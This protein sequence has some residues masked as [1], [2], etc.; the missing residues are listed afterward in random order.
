MA[1][2]IDMLKGGGEEYI[3]YPRAHENIDKEINKNDILGVL[4]GIHSVTPKGMAP[5]IWETKDVFN[6][7]K[8]PEGK[9]I[10]DKILKKNKSSIK[11]LRGGV[12]AS[13]S[14]LPIGILT[15]LLSG[16]AIGT[17][18]NQKFDLSGKISK[19][20]RPDPKMGTKE[21]HDED[22]DMLVKIM[23]P[24]AELKYLKQTGQGY[25]A[26]EEGFLRAEPRDTNEILLQLLREQSN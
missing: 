8:T 25:P 7:A 1:N 6:E 21:Q 11:N 5:Q 23:S 17:G 10:L 18:I 19:W 4:S 26:D 15:A 2:L 20:L 16:G 14:S 3:S 24:E 9:S 22:M 13:A 12:G